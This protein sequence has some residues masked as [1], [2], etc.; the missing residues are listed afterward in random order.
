MKLTVVGFTYSPQF[1][2]TVHP[3]SGAVTGMLK[4]SGAAAGCCYMKD[5]FF[6]T[7]VSDPEKAMRR[8]IQVADTGHHSIAGHAQVSLL[9]EGIPKIVAMYLNNLRDYETSEKSGRYTVM[10]DVSDEE[11]TL[12]NKW[13][14]IFKDRITEVYGEHPN[15]D[16]IPVEKL[17]MENARYVLSVFYPTTMVHTASL[18]QWNYIIDWA[19]EFHKRE[20]VMTPLFQKLVPYFRELA[21]ELERLLYVGTLRDTKER[22]F[23]LLKVGPV[24]SSYITTM[25]CL[26]DGY[27]ATSVGSFAMFAQLQRHRT[28]K[29][30]AT[31]P[32]AVEDFTFFLP[33]ILR[34]TKWEKEWMDDLRSVAHLYPNATLLHIQENGVLSDFKLKA[35]ERLCGRAQWEIMRDTANKVEY[36]PYIEG[37]SAASKKVV[38]SLYGGGMCATKCILCKG[39]KEPCA[40]GAKEALIRSI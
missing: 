14:A 20:E 23:D 16:R 22:K 9:I 39:C 40:F 4:L 8:F 37:L 10:E 13:L 15:F 7:S 30:T 2:T 24:P 5:Q 34:G 28:L 31:V 33:A 17:A 36:L 6:G 35:M 38:D 3:F 27:E 32:G 25:R 26:G 19:L 29:C 12:Y 11:R 21:C 18:R 1:T